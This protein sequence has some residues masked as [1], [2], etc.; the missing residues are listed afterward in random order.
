MVQDV[1]R[2][3]G[4]RQVVAPVGALAAA[5]TAAPAAHSH[6]S[7]GTTRPAAATPTTGAAHAAHATHFAS[8]GARGRSGLTAAPAEAEGFAQAEVD[9]EPSGTLAVVARDDLLARLRVQIER[10]ESRHDD[11]GRVRVGGKGGP[12]SE[13]RVT[14][15]V[16]A[17]RDVERRA[18]AGHD[19]RAEADVVLGR[20]RSHQ[21]E[22]VANVQ[23]RAAVLAAEVAGIRRERA[24]AIGVALGV[25][26]HVEAVDRDVLGEAAIDVGDE[27]VL[28]EDSVGL[29]LVDPVARCGKSGQP[30]R[31]GQDR[32][33][34]Q[35]VRAGVGERQSYR[36]V[37][38]QLALQAEG[39][40][41]DVRRPEI[42]VLH[43]DRLR[44]LLGVQL[45]D[46]RDG[47]EEVGVDDDI[48]RLGGSVVPDRLQRVVVVEAAVEHAKPA[49]DHGFLLALL[50]SR[51][52][53]EADAGPEIPPIVD[54]GLGFVAQSQV[55][56][57]VRLHAPIVLKERPHV[58]LRHRC[59]GSAAGDGEL[60]RASTELA[61]ERG[62]VPQLLEVQGAPVP[63]ERGDL[64]RHR[65]AAGSR[66]G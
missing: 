26:E 5:K 34:E 6:S 8:A 28:P 33:A 30:R 55:E 3:G 65:V 37:G 18:G 43:A 57:E 63:V 61:D 22:A 10:P 20:H 40:L 24:R 62:T 41:E 21:H 39:G 15:Q 60:R 42:A 38:R 12:G 58:G 2:H 56:G 53:G 23:R 19:E 47:G 13:Q 29:V 1:S 9:G 25:V 31:I 52:P 66:M 4:E 49:A 44:N 7:T 16:L 59:Q 14:V 64:A 32:G 27:L 35:V 36:R 51:C 11:S 48:L 46:R 54:V 45:A 17:H 50:G